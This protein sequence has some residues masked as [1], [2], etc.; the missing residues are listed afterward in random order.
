MI[1]SRIR[2]VLLALGVLLG[3][4]GAIAHFSHRD[5]CQLHQAHGPPRVQPAQPA[6]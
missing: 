2:I 1:D 5:R 4:G 3:Y 6:G